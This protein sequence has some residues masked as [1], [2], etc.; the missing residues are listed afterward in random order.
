MEGGFRVESF[1]PEE[2]P[3]FVRFPAFTREWERLGLDDSA[4]QAL[5]A[6]ILR[7]PTR[8]PVIRGTGGLRKLRFAAPGSGRGRSGAFRVCYVDFP[9]FGTMALVVVFGK[10]EKVDLTPADRKAIASALQAYR[11]ELEREFGRTRT[12]IER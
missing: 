12:S 5:E 1:K 8:A 11:A 9:E 2:W 10:N 3:R 7:G 4:L 6:E